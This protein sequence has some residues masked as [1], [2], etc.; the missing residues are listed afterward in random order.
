MRT[1]HIVASALGV[2][3][4]WDRLAYFL[5]VNFY[6]PHPLKFIKSDSLVNRRAV[7]LRAGPTFK[8]SVV[9]ARISLSTIRHA[10]RRS[11][12]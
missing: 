10:S 3:G 12:H 4:V 1:Y 9:T 11:N 8:F 7:K 2:E 6:L 5:P